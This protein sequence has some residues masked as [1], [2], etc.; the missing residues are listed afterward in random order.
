[1]ATGYIDYD[2]LEAAAKEFKPKIII[3]GFSAY[4]RDLDYKRFRQIA[5]SVGAYLLADM[6]H[7]SGLVA[8]EELNNP[9]EYAHVV[10]TTT[11]KSLRGP[12]SGMI[13]ARKELMDKIDFAVFPMLQG[14]PHNHQVAAIASQLKQVN[15]PEFKHY[16][17]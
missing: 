11:H 5:D 17:K 15:T 14:G 3:A 1:L 6:A 7:I 13:F 4:P 10:S 16:S 9:F 8:A 12:R 2:A